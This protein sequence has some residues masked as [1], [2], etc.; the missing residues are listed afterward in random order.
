MSSQIEKECTLQNDNNN[1]YICR[2]C[3][4]KKNLNENN[5]ILFENTF[6]NIDLMEK[7]L[8][9]ICLN[10]NFDCMNILKILPIISRK[11]LLSISGNDSFNYHIYTKNIPIIF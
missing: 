7:L 1:E 6:C 2:Y 8:D 11:I 4:L 9:I 5:K 3:L 10:E